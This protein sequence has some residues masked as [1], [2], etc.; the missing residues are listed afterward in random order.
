VRFELDRDL[1]DPTNV[2]I[3]ESSSGDFPEAKPPRPGFGQ[4][5]DP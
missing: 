5:Y 2:W 4:P 1:D 3:T